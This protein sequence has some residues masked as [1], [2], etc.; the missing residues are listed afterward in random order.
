MRRSVRQNCSTAQ[1]SGPTWLRRELILF[2]LIGIV[3][4][5]AIFA[6]KSAF[7]FQNIGNTGN[8]TACTQP[9]GINSAWALLCSSNPNAPSHLRAPGA[10]QFDLFA[11]DQH[12]STAGQKIQ[13]DYYYSL[14]TAPSEISMLAETAVKTR[15]QVTA[16]IQTQIDSVASPSRAAGRQRLGE[17]RHQLADH[18]QLSRHGQ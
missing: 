7:G 14:L 2:R 13:A 16:D 6:N 1:R 10:D 11:D 3:F 4:V 5:Q 12:L 15:M 9:N 18:R 17:R 8:Q